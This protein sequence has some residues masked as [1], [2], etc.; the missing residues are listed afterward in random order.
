M[1]V[2]YPFSM[3]GCY[4]QNQVSKDFS[5][6]NESETVNCVNQVKEDSERS[7]EAFIK[8]FSANIGLISK[9]FSKNVFR[10]NTNFDEDD[11]FSIAIFGFFRSIQLFEPNRGV[12]FS[13]Y[14]Y[15]SMM[16][17]IRQECEKIKYPIKIPSRVQRKF[18]EIKEFSQYFE[19][20]DDNEKRINKITTKLGIS[21]NLLC[22]VLSIP[23]HFI[24]L[25]DSVSNNENLTYQDIIGITCNSYKDV[26][27]KIDNGILLN[28]LK[29]VLNEKEQYIIFNYY[30][31]NTYSKPLKIIAKNLNTS[32]KNIKK[33]LYRILTKLKKSENRVILNEL[34]TGNDKPNERRN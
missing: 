21:R 20:T 24:Y 18:N 19:S 26:D 7:E 28:F 23:R 32:D 14:A 16:F 3:I 15:Q 31:I 17:E 4:F 6:L 29:T 33:L 22:R 12:K 30:G 1:E 25:D 2:Y 11:L 34:I 5:L 13:T 8:L 9:V 27:N 10:L